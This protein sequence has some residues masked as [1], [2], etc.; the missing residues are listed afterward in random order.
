MTQQQ[1]DEMIENIRAEREKEFEAM[2]FYLRKMIKPV[3]DTSPQ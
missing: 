3:S 1:F 2:V